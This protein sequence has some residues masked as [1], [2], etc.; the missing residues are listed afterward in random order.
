MAQECYHPWRD[1]RPRISRGHIS[2]ATREIQIGTGFMKP[3]G[4]PEIF[5]GENI[6]LSFH[7]VHLSSI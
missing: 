6:F 1:S 3:Q 7:L 4:S 5:I 2:L